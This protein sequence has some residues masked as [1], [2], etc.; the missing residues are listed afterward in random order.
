MIS[1]GFRDKTCGAVS[2]CAELLAVRCWL[3][4]VPCMRRFRDLCLVVSVTVVFVLFAACSGDDPPASTGD[5]VVDT[6][7][8]STVPPTTTVPPT[9]TGVLESVDE[10]VA[11]SAGS[12]VQAWIELAW[13]APASDPFGYDYSLWV[14]E[15]AAPTANA[16]GLRAGPLTVSLVESAELGLD[17]TLTEVMSADLRSLL[18]WEAAF[19]GGDDWRVFET[20]PDF[21]V[22]TV[23]DATAEAGLASAEDTSHTVFDGLHDP[24]MLRD[25]DGNVSQVLW[26][27]VVDVPLQRTDVLFGLVHANVRFGTTLLL[28]PD[29][30]GDGG[31]LI[32][33][34]SVPDGFIQRSV[35][36]FPTS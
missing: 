22:F 3:R 33:A 7:V 27:V 35:V 30:A 19:V 21:A 6:A 23:S 4:T 13:V 28:V 24:M 12:V 1:S 32:E 16:A 10:S 34:T 31:F 36:A 14:D 5:P 15:L 20:D 17:D 25:N 8:S 9:S 26:P 11:S 29:S 2:V 18:W